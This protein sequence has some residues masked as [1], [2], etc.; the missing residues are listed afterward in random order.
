MKT[1][2]KILT[3][4]AMVFETAKHYLIVKQVANRGDEATSGS[5]NVGSWI[6]RASSISTIGLE[7][8]D[9]AF[10]VGK[11]IDASK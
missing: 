2:V 5:N 8:N 11:L 4:G 6:V 3:D 1:T 7:C 10:L 9:L